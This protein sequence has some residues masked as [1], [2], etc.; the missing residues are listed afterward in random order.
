MYLG[1]DIGTGGTRAKVRK[2]MDRVVLGHH[3]VQGIG[4]LVAASRHPRLASGELASVPDARGLAGVVAR[5]SLSPGAN[6]SSRSALTMWRGPQ[7]QTGTT[8]AGVI[9]NCTP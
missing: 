4:F 8:T 6:S 3:F 2:L 5:L 7:I 9:S 1:I